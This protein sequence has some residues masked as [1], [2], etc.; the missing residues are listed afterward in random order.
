MGLSFAAL[1]VSPALVLEGLVQ[2]I[3]YLKDLKDN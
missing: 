1:D 2:S 3:L